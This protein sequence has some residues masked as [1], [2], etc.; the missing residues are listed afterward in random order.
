MRYQGRLW[1]LSLYSDCLERIINSDLPPEDL[2][3]GVTAIGRTDSLVSE[4]LSEPINFMA[5]QLADK[6]PQRLQGAEWETGILRALEPLFPATVRHTGGPSEQGADLEVIISNPFDDSSDWIVPIQI[7]DHQGVEGIN[8][9]A[10]LEQAYQSRVAEDRGN[11]IAVV[12]LATDAEPSAELQQEMSE[13]REKYHI[14]FI[15]C[16]GTQLMRT[17]ARGFLKGV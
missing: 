7:K 15:F 2:A 8:V 11:V 17:L 16:G 14:P 3:L 13:L 5:D 9:V 6:L 10:Q 4:L 1:R 12:L